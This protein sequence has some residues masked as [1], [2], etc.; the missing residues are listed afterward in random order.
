[1]PLW[2][3]WKS[4]TPC[5]ALPALQTGFAAAAG[6]KIPEMAEIMGPAFLDIVITTTGAFR[7]SNAEEVWRAFQHHNPAALLI[8]DTASGPQKALGRAG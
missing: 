2:F 4:S 8:R 5:P 6:R 1:M 7:E 3:A